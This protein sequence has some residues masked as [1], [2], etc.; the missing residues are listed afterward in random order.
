[1]HLT[2]NA[3]TLSRYPWIPSISPTRRMTKPHAHIEPSCDTAYDL[4]VNGVNG[5]NLTFVTQSSA[6]A[7]TTITRTKLHSELGIHRQ[8]LRFTDDPLRALS[9]HFCA[10]QNSI[11]SG[12]LQAPC[13]LS[14]FAHTV[15]SCI[16]ARGIYSHCVI[17]VFELTL[18]VG[19]MRSFGS[20]VSSA[21][22]YHDPSNSLSTRH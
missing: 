6:S 5:I 21:S 22:E 20:A 12:A 14:L 8:R 15:C 13:V 2:I 7:L 17:P 11:I 3:L 9:V 18:S 1:M 4:R 10:H 16:Q 19:L